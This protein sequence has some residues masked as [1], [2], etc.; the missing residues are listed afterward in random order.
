MPGIE[1]LM[2]ELG[3]MEG[4]LDCIDMSEIINIADEQ[5]IL[6][7][8]IPPPQDTTNDHNYELRGHDP[9]F[10]GKMIDSSESNYDSAFLGNNVHAYDRTIGDR[11]SNI[12]DDNTILI[13]FN[14]NTNMSS[15]NMCH[16]SFVKL[17][18]IDPIFP[19]YTNPQSY[20][21]NDECEYISF[22]SGHYV[23]DADNKDNLK[24]EIIDKNGL[25][26]D[27]N[28]TNFGKVLNVCK[29]YDLK[30]SMQI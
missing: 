3:L 13:D 9:F 18:N 26:S 21:K 1:G 16:N 11:K 29:Q 7:S 12:C 15:E 6:E 2:D 28:E 23:E 8:F 10:E 30:T 17:E 19:N 4:C 25:N 27:L 14:N 24:K 5:N 20:F 22:T